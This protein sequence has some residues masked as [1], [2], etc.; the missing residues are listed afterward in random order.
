MGTCSSI[1]HQIYSSELTILAKRSLN[2]LEVK[3]NCD[4]FDE[5]DL[6]LRTNHIRFE[7]LNYMLKEFETYLVFYRYLRHGA[8]EIIDVH[9]I[10]NKTITDTIVKKCNLRIGAYHEYKLD[11]DCAKRFICED[12]LPVGQ[13]MILTYKR[14]LGANIYLITEHTLNL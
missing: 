2:H 10:L 4:L 14:Y 6:V 9:N 3:I 11:H 13:S 5:E 1:D 12:L 8:F 7:E